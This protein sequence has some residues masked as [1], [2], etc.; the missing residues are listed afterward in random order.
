[1]RSSEEFRS[2]QS[3]GRIQRVLVIHNRY[4]RGMPGGEDNA[5]DQEVEML[6]D[7]GLVVQT[8]ERSNDEVRESNPITA[9]ATAF[10]MAH[11][12]RTV[13]D[14]RRILARFRPDVAHFHNTFPL[15][16]ASGYSACREAGV[17]VV[18]TLHN[19]RLLCTAATFYRDGSPCTLCTPRSHRLGIKYRCYRSTTGSFFV[20]RMLEKH[21]RTGVYTSLVD[22]YIVLTRFAVERFAA[23]GIDR[24]R[25][26]IKPNFTRHAPEPG[27]G[28]GNYAL[29]AGKLSPEKG[30]RTLLEAWSRLAH[31]PLK[32]VGTGPLDSE[33]RA[34]AA[35][36]GLNVEFLGMRSRAETIKLMQDAVLLVLPSEWFEGFPLV[37][38]ESYASGT[39]VVASRIGGLPELVRDGVTGTL[40]EP[41]DPSSLAAAV[42]GL[43]QRRD[44]I[45]PLRMACR[46]VFEAELSERRNLQMLLEIYERTKPYSRPTAET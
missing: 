13:R 45:A 29:F 33:L 41:R 10:Q 43:W 36:R 25:I 31:V 9:A 30:L 26:S 3:A 7:A 21:W 22:H 11:S 44:E 18:Q 32:I 6:R 12:R 38:T 19:Y 34:R 1:M 17:P 20:A 42:S 40:F 16:T 35:D 37:I 8:Y 28:A 27:N 23:A 14:L 46:A 2:A 15:I 4:R 24:S 5:F 39:P